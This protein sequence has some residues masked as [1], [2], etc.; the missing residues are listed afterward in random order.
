MQY[1]STFVAKKVPSNVA[2]FLEVYAYTSCPCLV[3]ELF[4]RRRGCGIIGQ[5]RNR[6]GRLYRYKED[7]SAGSIPA[8]L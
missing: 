6:L 8:Q 4:G 5:V 7:V 1:F 2:T 3:L